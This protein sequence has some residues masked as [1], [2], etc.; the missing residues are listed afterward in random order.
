MV[1]SQ[2]WS[3][4]P[5]CVVTGCHVSPLQNAFSLS[6]A[7]LCT[8]AHDF[9]PAPF[10]SFSP[11]R[12]EVAFSRPLLLLSSGTLP[13]STGHFYPGVYSVPTSLQCSHFF[14]VF[15]CT[16]QFPIFMMFLGCTG[17]LFGSKASS[18]IWCS[19]VMVSPL[20]RVIA[21][22]PSRL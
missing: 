14:T 21:I 15:E 9:Q 18:R 12:L 7:P 3:P 1:N 13:S 5:I 6:A 16:L 8:S 11:V 4:S 19:C 20:K 2:L 10:L 17:G 22:L